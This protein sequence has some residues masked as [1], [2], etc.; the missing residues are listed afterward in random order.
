MGEVENSICLIARVKEVALLC[1]ETGDLAIGFIRMKNAD[2]T[3][4]PE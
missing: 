3:K 4:L 1:V 2:L